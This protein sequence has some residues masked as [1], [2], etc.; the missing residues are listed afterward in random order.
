VRKTTCRVAPTIAIALLVGISQTSHAAFRIVDSESWLLS[1]G[2]PAIYWLD[3]QSVL[4]IG[5]GDVKRN[6][7]PASDLAL[8]SWE[9]GKPRVLIRRGVDTVCYRPGQIMYAVRD[10]KTKTRT[11]YQGELGR[12]TIVQAKVLN[13]IRCDITGEPDRS[14]NRSV[15]Q[16]LPG[17]GYLYMGPSLG[18]E[19]SKN[20]PARPITEPKATGSMLI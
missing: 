7:A 14:Q 16:L 6:L 17:H 5:D 18:K 3:N 8:F 4:Y 13:A 1:G 11:F 9:A 20:T 2:N 15:Q 19:S 12:E 10:I